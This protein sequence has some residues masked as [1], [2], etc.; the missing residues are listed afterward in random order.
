MK[1]SVAMNRMQHFVFVIQASLTTVS[2]GEEFECSLGVDA[3][4]R[5]SYKPCQKYNESSGTHSLSQP[6]TFDL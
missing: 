1:F 4:V 3:A 6:L 5:V 2:P